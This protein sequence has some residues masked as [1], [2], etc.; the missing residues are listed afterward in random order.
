MPT[1]YNRGDFG[2]VFQAT[3]GTPGTYVDVLGQ[4]RDD[5][6]LTASVENRMPVSYESAYP[7][8]GQA[9][10]FTLQV[11]V[12][13]AEGSI[14]LYLTGHFE[15]DP[16]APFGY[17]YTFDNAD[18]TGT[19]TEKVY[20]TTQTCDLLQTSNGATITEMSV[21]VIPS[22]DFDGD[23]SVKLQAK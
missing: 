1:L 13:V 19:T 10:D 2:I 16:T 23:I 9:S 12:Y 15:Q 11:S 4:T 18:P 7:H 22:A 5:L 14:T 21:M 6:A 20:T 3:T 8:A 17:L